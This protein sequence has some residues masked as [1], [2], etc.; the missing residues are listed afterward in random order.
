MRL[1][2]Q[3]SES[4]DISRLTYIVKESLANKKSIWNHD[5]KG[6][7]TKKCIID[8]LLQHVKKYLADYWEKNVIILPNK[9]QDIDVDALEKRQNKYNI[10]YAIETDIDNGVLANEIIKYIASYLHMDKKIEI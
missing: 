4:S 7:K 3:L 5:Y 10:I 1:V 8:P 2:R 9:K 6:V